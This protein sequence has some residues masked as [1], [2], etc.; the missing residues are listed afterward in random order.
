MTILKEARPLQWA[1][2]NSNKSLQ[3]Q[4]RIYKGYKVFKM[5]RDLIFWKMME[6]IIAW[7]KLWVQVSYIKCLNKQMILQMKMKNSKKKSRKLKIKIQ[8]MNNS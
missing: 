2:K 8:K 1:N 7:T 3:I 6:A 5:N 4:F